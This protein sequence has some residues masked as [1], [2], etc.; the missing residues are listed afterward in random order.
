MVQLNN[1]RNYSQAQRWP[2]TP[3]RDPAF[4]KSELLFQ[5]KKTDVTTAVGLVG[6]LER[7]GL[8]SVMG[9][10]SLEALRPADRS[11]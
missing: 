9:F 11:H 6:H 7:G 1:W 4:F 8:G 10:L 5:G 2:I 3:D